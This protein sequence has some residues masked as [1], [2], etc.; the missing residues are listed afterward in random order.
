MTRRNFIK[1]TGLLIIGLI[2]TGCG[3][4]GAQDSFKADKKKK[5]IYYTPSVWNLG[6]LNS[7]VVS[8][9]GMSGIGTS[10]AVHKYM[11]QIATYTWFSGDPSTLP[12]DQTSAILYQNKI[13]WYKY[14]AL[15]YPVLLSTYGALSSSLIQVNDVIFYN[16]LPGT[17]NSDGTI[18]Y[19]RTTMSSTYIVI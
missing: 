9:V 15:G 4:A 10:L 14:S 5:P 3:G 11:D 18:G 8:G 2:V 13:S 1:D 7:T 16:L 12:V 6:I 17:V 19:G